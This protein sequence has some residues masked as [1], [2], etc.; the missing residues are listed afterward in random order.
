MTVT[1]TAQD[2]NNKTLKLTSII[3]K[4]DPANTAQYS[5]ASSAGGITP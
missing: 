3:G 1:W 4:I 5:T 2:G